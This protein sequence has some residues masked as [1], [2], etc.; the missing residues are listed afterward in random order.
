MDKITLRKVQLVQLDI[1]KEIAKVCE[2]NDVKYFLI[3]GTLLGA[4]RHGGFIPWDDDLDIGMLRCDYDKF[5]KIAPKKLSP[6]YRL[7]NWKNDVN[8]PH[9]M[10]KVIKKG[11]I[12][13]EKKRE[14]LGEQGIWV[15]I[16]P[17]DNIDNLLSLKQ[18]SFRLKV[19]RGLIRTKNN[20]MTWVTQDGF[21]YKKYI[22]NIPFKIVSPFFNRNTLI[23][24]YENISVKDN[25]KETEMVFEN[26]VEDYKKWFFPKQYFENLKKVKFEDAYFWAPDNYHEYLCKAYGNY[27]KLPPVNEREN[28]HLIEEIDLGE[29]K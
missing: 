25:N 7:I 17:Y 12:Y 21:L 16:F 11:T 10:G 2:M 14:D 18:K 4:V 15:D 28:R 23:S 1:A 20:Y 8:Y 22:K 24:K 5:L 6:E 29:K 27:M 13:K 26:G 19:L 3:G 9:P